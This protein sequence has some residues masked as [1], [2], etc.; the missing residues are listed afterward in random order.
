MLDLFLMFAK[1]GITAFGGGSIIISLIQKEFV[2]TGIINMTDFI[3]L[4]SLSQATPGPI[5]GSAAT[6]IGYRMYG[7]EGALISN[8]GVTLPSFLIV[9]IFARILQHIHDN[10]CVGHVL[11]VLRPINVALIISV[12][13]FLFNTAIINIA[14]IKTINDL[15]ASFNIGSIAIFLTALF[16]M[17]K[18]KLNPIYVV[19]ISGTMG[20][21]ML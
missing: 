3:R 9:L 5:A 20:A 19:I 2:E 4:L 12:F 18:L 10:E 7:L 21:I 8:I 17:T 13:I 11:E 6:Y 15:A 16:S 1:I 14:Q